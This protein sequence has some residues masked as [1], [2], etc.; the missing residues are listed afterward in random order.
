MIDE[1]TK[2]ELQNIIEGD[3]LSGTT[4]LIKA[5]QRFL[6]ENES[7][8]QEHSQ[9][10][11]FKNQ[12]K[13]KLIGF[14]EENRLW[15][16][17]DINPAHYIT[18]GAEQKV[19]FFDRDYII[20]LNSGIFYEKWLDYFNSLLVHNYFFKSTAYILLGFKLIDNELFAVVKQRFVEANESTDLLK[21][22]E[23]LEYNHFKNIRNNDYIHDDLGLILEDLHDENV[24]TKDNILYFIDTVFYLTEKFYQKSG[25]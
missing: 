22:K 4:T 3:G 6:R 12:E 13:N 15:Y 11:S 9:S 20:K 5:V 14:I 10:K 17:T 19:Y 25:K 23:L 24:L 18:E 2:Y 16:D 7:T 8:S 1:S 21:L